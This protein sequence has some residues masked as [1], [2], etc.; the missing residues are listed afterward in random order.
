MVLRIE[1]SRTTVNG[2]VAGVAPNLSSPKAEVFDG[3]QHLERAR[4][5]LTAIDHA[6]QYLRGLRAAA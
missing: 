6:G 1:I 3:E 4:D 5:V 2:R